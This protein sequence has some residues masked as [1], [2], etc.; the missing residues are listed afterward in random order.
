MQATTVVSL[1]QPTI[2]PGRRFRLE[3]RDYRGI[4]RA[5]SVE[6]SGD[7]GWETDFYTRIS[8]RAV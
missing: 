7:S 8:A 1:L 6:H 4:Y 3:S 2:R 5:I